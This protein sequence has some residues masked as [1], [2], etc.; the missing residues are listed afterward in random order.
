MFSRGIIIK[1]SQKVKI[2]VVK[3]ILNN[4]CESKYLKQPIARLKSE[5]GI[6]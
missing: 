3:Q 2:S 4:Q 1:A 5:I 6:N